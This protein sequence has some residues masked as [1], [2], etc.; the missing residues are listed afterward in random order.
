MLGIAC[1]L[2]IDPATNQAHPGLWFT[3]GLK[4]CCLRI[5]ALYRAILRQPAQMTAGFPHA[6]DAQLSLFSERRNPD[7][8][9]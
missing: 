3:H 1:C 6:T 5:G 2:V 8:E 4:V 7:T 9:P